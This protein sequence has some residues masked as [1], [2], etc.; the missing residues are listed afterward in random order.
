MVFH[1]LLSL[2][3]FQKPKIFQ[4]KFLLKW[5]TFLIDKSFEILG[6][7]MQENLNKKRISNKTKN[8]SL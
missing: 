4:Q 3:L 5:I 6:H 1:S 8:V 7:Y 2:F